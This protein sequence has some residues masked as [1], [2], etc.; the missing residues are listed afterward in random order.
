MQYLSMTQPQR[1]YLSTPEMYRYITDVPQL[2][3]LMPQL[4]AKIPIPAQ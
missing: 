4:T 1:L 3:E 2:K